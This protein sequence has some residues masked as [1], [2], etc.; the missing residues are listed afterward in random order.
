M[1]ITYAVGSQVYFLPMATAKY[2]CRQIC[3]RVAIRM[4]NSE[5]DR[6]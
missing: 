5:L 1:V 4:R 3:N 2:D 6:V